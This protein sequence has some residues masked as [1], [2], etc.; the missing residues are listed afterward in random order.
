MDK[1]YQVFVSSTYADL[2]EEREKVIHTLMEMNCIPAGME[3]FPAA[4]EEQ[5]EFIKRIINDC[6]Y[7]LLIIG[8][9]Y[10]SVTDEGISYTEKE[11][12]YAL[13]RKIKVIAFLHKNPEQ[14]PVNKSEQKSEL[15]EKLENFRSKVD[16]TRLVKYWQNIEELPGL[17]APSLASTIKLYPAVGWVRADKVSSEELLTEINE[18]R[19][20]NEQLQKE[21]SEFKSSIFTAEE[22]K[23]FSHIYKIICRSEVINVTY[24]TAIFGSDSSTSESFTYEEQD[25]SE[26]FNVNLAS[27]IALLPATKA[28]YENYWEYVPDWIIEQLVSTID[29]DNNFFYPIYSIFVGEKLADEL[30]TY[31]F[32]KKQYITPLSPQKMSF[33]SHKKITSELVYSEKLERYKYWLRVNDKM[34]KCIELYVKEN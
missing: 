21:L 9:R 16:K 15:R 22:E 2:K 28:I 32:L 34:P 17:V 8:G 13:E 20:K 19:K 1:R 26:S 10:G 6:D 5:L 23:E 27:L 31:G 29:S 3:L 30:L 18:L 14:I 7:Y 33:P 11:Y 25:R 24:H 4:D 12:E